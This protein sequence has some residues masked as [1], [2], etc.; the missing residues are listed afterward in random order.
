MA[1]LCA[2]CHTSLL[3]ESSAAHT[4]PQ[5]RT[6]RSSHLVWPGPRPTHLSPLLISFCVFAVTDCSHR[7]IMFH[8][9]FWQATGPEGGLGDPEP[10]CSPKA[11]LCSRG[12][13]AQS[14]GSWPRSRRAM[15]SGLGPVPRSPGRACP[16]QL[17]CLS[18]APE[19][20][21]APAGTT[22]GLCP[23]QMSERWAWAPRRVPVG[24][25]YGAAEAAKA[26]CLWGQQRG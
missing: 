25:D 14:P 4:T 18:P 17:P 3:G 10:Q 21:S 23:G 19:K 15:G 6:P 24:Q 8:E 11:L 5:E 26:F 20:G 7:S 9:S 16:S 22:T 2:C 12:K 13:Q 1:K